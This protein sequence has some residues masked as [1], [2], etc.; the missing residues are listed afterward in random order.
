MVSGAERINDMRK[1]SLEEL[2]SVVVSED[3][4]VMC[5]AQIIGLMTTRWTILLVTTT[6]RTLTISKWYEVP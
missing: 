5:R 4:S 2:S 1:A 6:G 3:V